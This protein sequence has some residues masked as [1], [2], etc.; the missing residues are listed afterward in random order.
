MKSSIAFFYGMK[1]P[2]EGVKILFS[3]A[4]YLKY[5]WVSALLNA[6]LYAFI[7]YLLFYHV[8]PWVNSWFPAHTASG[9]LSFLYHSIEYI[10]K[11]IISLTFLVISVILFN[12]V[13]F[14]LSAPYLDGLSLAVE[15]DY[16]GF[17]PGLSGVSGFAKACYVSIKNGIRLNILTIF[18]AVILFPLN[19][20]IPVVGFL[21]GM[22]VGS[23]FLGLSFIIFSAEHRLLGKKELKD[24]LSGNRL[25]VLGLGLMMYLILFIPFSAIFFIPGAVIGGALLYNEKI[26]GS[27]RI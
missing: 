10:I 6:V 19:F 7:L 26:E 4:K 23:Y 12:T 20:I 17:T 5:A 27:D 3:K 21:P 24:R 2:F 22:L 9:W 11:T 13:F 1:T 8:F 25:G 14:A 18:W 15:K 16:F